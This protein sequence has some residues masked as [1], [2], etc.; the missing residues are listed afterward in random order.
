[1]IC[2]QTRGLTFDDRYDKIITNLSKRNLLSPY[3]NTQSCVPI[4]RF[5]TQTDYAYLD[6]TL[7]IMKFVKIIAIVASLFVG[8]LTTAKADADRIAQKF[9]NYPEAEK[10]TRDKNNVRF[11]FIEEGK[12]RQQTLSRTEGD[13]ANLRQSAAAK[14]FKDSGPKE[15][16][17][18]VYATWEDNEEKKVREIEREPDAPT[19][20]PR[21]ERSFAGKLWDSLFNINL[22]I[23]PTIAPNAALNGGG[24]GNNGGWDNGGGWNGNNGGMFIGQ[25][26][27]WGDPFMCGQI[28]YREC[29]PWGWGRSWGGGGGFNRGGCNDFAQQRVNSRGQ[30][31]NLVN[32]I[33]VD[34][35]NTNNN[36]AT[37]DNRNGSSVAVN[38]GN[39]GGYNP[40]GTR[41][42]GGSGGG[43]YN[44]RG[45]REGAHNGP[46]QHV[47]AQG[48]RTGDPRGASPGN[49]QSGRGSGGY[50][51]PRASQQVS[52]SSGGG[53]SYNP[54]G[55]R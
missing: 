22:T 19:P 25:Q 44:P 31:V 38:P 30:G 6:A 15:S 39:G 47:H 14:F 17:D 26:Q 42:S 8:G 37:N 11:W 55:A 12:N 33:R 16:Y 2:G 27:W 5:E 13:G 45:T 49:Y 7:K 28:R 23:A 21:R 10:S 51:S 43:G 52:R 36:N 35:R 9:E 50:Y 41:S 18:G 1:M 32:N 40:H 34:S 46:N 48:A 3:V 53:G 4:Y 20:P 29:Q 24:W 54:R